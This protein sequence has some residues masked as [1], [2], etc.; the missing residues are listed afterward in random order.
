MSVIGITPAQPARGREGMRSARSGPGG[1]GHFYHDW[2]A[3]V[4]ALTHGEAEAS[5]A[6]LGPFEEML[7][8]SGL[9]SSGRESRLVSPKGHDGVQRE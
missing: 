6:V 4:G 8:D 5:L 9:N 2:V 1:G 7:L 3:A